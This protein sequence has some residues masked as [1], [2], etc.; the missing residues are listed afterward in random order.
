MAGRETFTRGRENF[1]RGR[2]I[3]TRGLYVSGFWRETLVERFGA[4]LGATIGVGI[5]ATKHRCNCLIISIRC[6]GCHQLSPF[7]LKHAHT[8]TESKRRETRWTKGERHEGRKTSRDDKHQNGLYSTDNQPLG[9]L[10][11]HQ[12][13][14]N[15]CTVRSFAVSLHRHSALR[16]SNTWLSLTSTSAP[17]TYRRKRLLF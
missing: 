16:P 8:H 2:E 11:F 14:P 3:F 4:T 9:S 15:S 13:P 12:P 10:G 7:R 17:H 6:A 1:M 5:G